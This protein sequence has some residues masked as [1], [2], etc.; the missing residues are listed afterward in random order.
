MRFVSTALAGTYVLELERHDDE[1][2]GF[3]RISCAREFAEHDLDARTAQ[4]S[5]SWNTVRGTLRGLHYQ[6][7]PHAEAK[8]VRAI[9]GAIFDVAVDLRAGS[10]TYGRW[11]GVELSETNGRA[12][13]IPVGCAHGFLTLADESV[14]LYQIS[15]P[16]EPGASRGIRWNDPTIQIQWPFTPTCISARDR[17][18][19]L[20]RP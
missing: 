10:S 3:A 6:A 16:Y 8:T 2:G 11:V 5:L 4:S 13:Y 12:L 15:V 19:P 17:E 14:V 1:R 7:E 20:F 18:L 9:A